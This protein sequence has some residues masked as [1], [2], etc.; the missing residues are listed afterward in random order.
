MAVIRTEARL[1]STKYDSGI[2]K[3]KGSNGS[4]EKSVT[5]MQ[6]RIKTFAKVAAGALAGLAAIKVL[7]NLQQ[8]TL[9]LGTKISDL[10]YQAGLTTDEFQGLGAAFR[11]AGQ[12]EDDLLKLTI[13]LRDSQATALAAWAEGKPEETTEAFDALGIAADKLAGMN[14]GQ[15]LE[16]IS[17]KLRAA[18]GAGAE[19]AAA[20]DL[21]GR[22]TGRSLE[23]LMNLGTVG[24]DGIITKGRAAGQIIEADIVGGLDK[25]ADWEESKKRQ[26]MVM[27]SNNPINKLSKGEG[28]GDKQKK[29]I[30]EQVAAQ[31]RQLEASKKQR[32]EE[33]RIEKAKEAQLK[34]TDEQIKKTSDLVS[35]ASG[36]MQFSSIASIG[37]RSSSGDV[38]NAVRT[39]LQ[40]LTAQLAE[41][42]AIKQNTKDGGG[43]AP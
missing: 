21:M 43:I 7:A 13:K 6:D 26:G 34:L 31:Q 15:L 39:Q 12:S 4:F 1:D 14:T 25:M 16:D 40:V 32:E 19:M 27:L 3:M 2:K 20:T 8:K 17:K 37:G 30:N 24:L 28:V 35:G 38:A 23:A 42:K 9:D 29:L 10:A 18:G 36:A 5:S 41:L 33:E 22:S 11:E